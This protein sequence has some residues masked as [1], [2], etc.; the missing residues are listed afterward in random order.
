MAKEYMKCST[1]VSGT[2]TKT[3]LSENSL[4]FFPEPT[5][6]FTSSHPHRRD[7]LNSLGPSTKFLSTQVRETER[8]ERGKDDERGV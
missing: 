3:F 2:K 4:T 5:L 8:D 7:A 6:T 1:V